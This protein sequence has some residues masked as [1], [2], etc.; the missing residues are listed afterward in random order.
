MNDNAKQRPNRL[1]NLLGALALLVHDRVHTS[2]E[3]VLGKGSSAPAALLSI[4]TR[5][6]QTIDHLCRTVGLS[7]SA[8]VRL[9]ETLSKEGLVSKRPGNDRRSTALFLTRKGARVF[10]RLL[11]RRREVIEGLTQSLSPRKRAAL[12]RT[13]E[14]LLDAVAEDKEEARRMCR[15]CEHEVC[16]PCPIG[17]TIRGG[18]PHV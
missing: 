6:Y 5:P 14:S 4:G 7:H 16:K 13:L 11:A 18:G 3:D 9:V 2:L 17:T 12:E 10:D 1:T 15:L 8:T